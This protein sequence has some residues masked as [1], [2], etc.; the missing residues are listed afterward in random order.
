MR[1]QNLYK[2]HNHNFDFLVSLKQ[3]LSPGTYEYKFIVDGKWVH[4]PDKPTAEDGKGGF[5][6]KITITGSYFFFLFFIE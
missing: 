1:V 2:Y 5:N 3:K 6:N 4:S